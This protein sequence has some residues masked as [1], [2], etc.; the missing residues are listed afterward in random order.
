MKKEMEKAASKLVREIQNATDII[1]Q[2]ITN[3][4][5]FLNNELVE[6]DKNL[7]KQIVVTRNAVWESIQDTQDLTMIFISDEIETKESQLAQSNHK[8]AELKAQLPPPP[9][10]CTMYTDCS[11]CTSNPQCGWC[12]S[13]QTC[14][15]G[16]DVGPT[17]TVCSFYNYQFCSGSGCVAFTSCN[18]CISNPFCGW[19]HAPAQGINNCLER[20]ST[21]SGCPASGWYDGTGTNA[22]CPTNSVAGTNDPELPYSIAT[23]GKNNVNAKIAGLS[24]AAQ[25]VLPIDQENI[26]KMQNE[27]IAEEQTSLKLEKEIAKLKTKLAGIKA[28]QLSN[29]IERRKDIERIRFPPM[30][31][32]PVNTTNSTNSTAPDAS[33]STLIDSNSTNSSSSDNSTNSTGTA[34]SLFSLF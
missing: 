25:S 1:N 13:S 20:P 32:M 31:T 28:K 27:L 12:A 7:T 17:Y 4:T 26:N 8:I 22:V 14:V 24:Q 5:V 2:T 10:V 6:T 18:T 21:Y 11:T 15:P 3:S 16:D 29:E 30:L 33:N 34:R 23:G 19:C 9:S